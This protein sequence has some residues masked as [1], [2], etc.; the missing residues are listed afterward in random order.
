M[1]KIKTFFHIFINS[2]F[3]LDHYY[4]KIIK[5]NLFFSLKY[6]FTLIFVSNAILI[7]VFILKSLLI[8]NNVNEFKASLINSLD[9]YP[10]NLTITIKNNQLTTNFDRPYIFWVTYKN[11]PHPLVVIDERA[12][13]EKVYQ[14]DSTTI[15]I[16][17]NGFIK[18]TE[19]G[20][21]FYPFKINHDLIVDKQRVE[22]LKNLVSR[23][24]EIFL[25]FVFII[26]VLFF[27]FANIFYLAVISF[28]GFWVIK[29]LKIKIGYKKVFQISLHSNTLPLICE[30]AILILGW[31]VRFP[32]WYLFLTLVFFST[33][34]YET[35]CYQA[36]EISPHKIHHKKHLHL[37]H[38]TGVGKTVKK[39]NTT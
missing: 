3:P 19:N 15:L 31:R 32:F 13:E 27:S 5:I 25:F 2:L 16:N 7:S 18:R 8:K 30:F 23:L 22:N 4:K 20:L 11:I 10:Q 28:F 12:P 24:S 6:F 14:F 34:I 17:S 36:P 37:P 9:N 21:R 29:I 26:L 35:Y 39:N 1:K 38:P 33:A